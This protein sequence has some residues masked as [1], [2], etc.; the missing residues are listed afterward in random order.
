MVGRIWTKGADGKKGL[1]EDG[2]GRKRYECHEERDGGKRQER[3]EE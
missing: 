2:N 3:Q 1:Q